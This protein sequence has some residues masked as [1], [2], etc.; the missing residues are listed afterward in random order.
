MVTAEFYYLGISKIK[1]FKA[2]SRNIVR[3]K[4]GGKKK[5]TWNSRAVVYRQYKED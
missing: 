2:Q 1:I 4:P 5:E 3:Y